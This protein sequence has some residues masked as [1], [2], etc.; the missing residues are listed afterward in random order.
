VIEAVVL[1]GG[2]GTRLRTAVPDL[3]KPMAPVAGRPFLAWLL[4]R[5]IAQGVRR[6]VL[7]VGYR[8][9]AIR[10]HF[11]TSYGGA[12]I[13]YAL[14]HSPLGTGGGMLLAAAQVP[15][16]EP[17]LLL[18]GDTLLD[19]ELRP[20]AEFHARRAADVTIALIPN[21]QEGRY[22]G[23]QVDPQGRITGFGMERARAAN[24]GVYLFNRSVLQGLEAA[25]GKATSLENELLPALI[26][27]GAHVY[28]MES[29]GGF[30]DIGVPEDYARAAAFLTN[31]STKKRT[32]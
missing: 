1:A 12:E 13:A 9:A 32:P 23:V 26:L 30:I 8:A 20:L 31:L 11:G 6:F 21:S 7:S 29:S 5:W 15:G 17:F 19:V 24:G 18:N 3:P 16:N 10:S 25:L 27:R 2:L 14:E 28:G 22:G 4:D